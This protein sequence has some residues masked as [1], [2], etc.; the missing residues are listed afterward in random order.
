MKGRLLRK[1]DASRL[2]QYNFSQAERKG[3][4]LKQWIENKGK[5]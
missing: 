5:N 2:G 4:W 1:L 3:K